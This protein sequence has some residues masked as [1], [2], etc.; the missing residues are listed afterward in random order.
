[1][2]ANKVFPVL[3][4]FMG[5]GPVES[6]LIVGF[7]VFLVW[8]KINKSYDP[9]WVPP[10]PAKVFDT[11]KCDRCGKSYTPPEPENTGADIYSMVNCTPETL[12]KAEEAQ[13]RA[14]LMALSQRGCPYCGNHLFTLG[15]FE[16][17]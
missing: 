17:E 15:Q 16:Q 2:I 14:Q 13:Q 3:F 8:R 1:M 6:F 4:A 7:L 5:L 10:P 11:H 12:I 9:N